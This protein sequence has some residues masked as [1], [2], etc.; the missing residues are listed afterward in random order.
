MLGYNLSIIMALIPTLM[1]VIGIPNCIYLYNKYHQ[2]YQLHKN[3]AKAL[4][5]VIKKTGTAMFLTNVTTALGFITF[6]FT[7]SEKFYEFGVIS[8]IN[9][10]LCFIV[11]LCLIP[12][13]ASF[14]R[15]PHDRH[16]NHLDRKAAVGIKQS[17]TMKQSIMLI[18]E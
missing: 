7:N 18:E 11:S 10:M 12:I 2:E 4:H 6:L 14:S 16:L 8:S 1:I 3:K 9:I 15:N 13:L 17:D 5:R